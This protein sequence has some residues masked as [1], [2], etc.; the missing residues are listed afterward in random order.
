MTD[1]KFVDVDLD[2]ALRAAL[3]DR[4][5]E[6]D[7]EVFRWAAWKA[8]DWAQ[9]LM[10]ADAWSRA[11]DA[12]RRKAGFDIRCALGGRALGD[13]VPEREIIAALESRAWKIWEQEA[14]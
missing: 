4:R 2:G 11:H 5:G 10:L 3:G 9:D 1:V 7:E 6:D 14:R 12:E 13:G 8:W